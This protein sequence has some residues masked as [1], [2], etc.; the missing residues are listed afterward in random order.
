M[1]NLCFSCSTRNT[2]QNLLK[3]LFQEFRVNTEIL[4][5]GQTVSCLLAFHSNK[6]SCP[7]GAIDLESKSH[8]PNRK[9]SCV[10]K[11]VSL[12]FIAH[13]TSFDINLDRRKNH[14][15]ILIKVW[16]RGAHMPN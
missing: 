14:D 15:I 5:G 12:A 6:F 3:L 9:A 4:S 7:D 8:F 10:A 13:S 2:L 1:D 16:V 11:I